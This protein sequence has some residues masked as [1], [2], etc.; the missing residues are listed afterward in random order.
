A[1]ATASR[2]WSRATVVLLETLDLP[3][4]FEIHLRIRG[5]QIRK[6]ARQAFAENIS[7]N[8]TRLVDL[9][10]CKAWQRNTS[11]CARDRDFR[12]NIVPTSKQIAPELLVGA[13]PLHLVDNEFVVVFDRF[14]DLPELAHNVSPFMGRDGL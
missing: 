2:L 8:L 5:V 11:R 12:F 6:L 10:Q 3:D 13:G 1:L 14:D 4:W 9:R 7:R